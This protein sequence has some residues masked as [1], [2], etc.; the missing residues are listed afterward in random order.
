MSINPAY[1]CS[2]HGL[3]GE[4]N[5]FFQLPID[6]F[7]LNLSSITLKAYSGIM[8]TNKTN[9]RF[10]KKY[11]LYIFLIIIAIA[12]ITLYFISRFTESN[13]I[14]QWYDDQFYDPEAIEP[15][16]YRGMLVQFVD[17]FFIYTIIALLIVWIV[18][19]VLRTFR[20]KIS[21]DIENTIRVLIRFIVILFFGIAYMTKFENFVGAIIGVAATVGAAFGLAASKSLGQLFSGLHLVLSKHHNVGDYLIIN[22]M[23]IEGVVTGISTSFVTILQPNKTT[24]VIPTDKLREEEVVNIKVEDFETEKDGITHLFL[25]GKKVRET[26]YVYPVKWATHSDDR[27]S[28]AVEAIMET[29]EDF[30]DYIDEEVDWMIYERDR[31]N[32]RYLISLTVIDPKILLHLAEDFTRILEANY[33]KIKYSNKKKSTS[34]KSDN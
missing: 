6:S 19:I 21:D 17:S 24:A 30:K 11:F 23:N 14:Q 1:L 29:G 31:L 12:I 32:R 10:K 22:D 16:D 33:E 13:F 3:G 34:K 9:S 20:E 15:L 4:I 7:I 8:N 27:H 5:P 25:Y 18:E 26:H 28:Q 2:Y